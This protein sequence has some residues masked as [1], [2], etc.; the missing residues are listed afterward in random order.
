MRVTE[1][2]KEVTQLCINTASVIVK[3]KNY[4]LTKCSS[5]SIEMKWILG[6]PSC[7]L[8]MCKGLHGEGSAAPTTSG[9]S[10]GIGYH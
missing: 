4:L 8:G 1:A 6:L 10:R 5:D 9:S 7:S 3:V 2:L